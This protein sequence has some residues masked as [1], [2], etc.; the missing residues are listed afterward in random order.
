[1]IQ[2]AEPPVGGIKAL[3]NGLVLAGWLFGGRQMDDVPKNRLKVAV[4]GTGISG[5][6]AAWLISQRHSVTVYERD[7]RLGGHSHTVNAPNGATTIPVDTGFIVYNEKTYPNLTALFAHLD[8]PTEPSEMSFAVS[9]DDGR[10]EY[11]GSRLAC[12]PRSATYSVRASGRCSTTF[13][14][15]IAKPQPT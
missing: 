9:L 11:S 4:I 14:A 6:S 8:V 12:L 13:T 5:M 3:W 10:L 15:S 2:T 7:E 1:M